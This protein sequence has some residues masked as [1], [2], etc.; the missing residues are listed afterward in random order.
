MLELEA[1]YYYY[2]E[3]V[4]VLLSINLQYNHIQLFNWATL[5]QR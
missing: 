4:K 5:L 2:Y 1:K 3:L